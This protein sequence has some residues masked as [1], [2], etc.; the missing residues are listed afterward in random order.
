MLALSIDLNGYAIRLYS[1]DN[2]TD[3]WA[4]DSTLDPDT[5]GYHLWGEMTGQYERWAMLY[6]LYRNNHAKIDLVP[7]TFAAYG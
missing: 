7:S 6:E 4:P 3:S 2:A 5:G 1:Y